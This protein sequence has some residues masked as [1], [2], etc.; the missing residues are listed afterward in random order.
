[1]DEDET[2]DDAALIEAWRAGDAVAGGRFIERHF[3]SVYRFFAT[4]LAQDADD[5]TQQTFTDLQRSVDRLRD[6]A[7]ARAY[8][9]RI[10]RNHLYMTLRSRASAGNVFD[11]SATSIAAIDSRPSPSAAV[12]R[13]AETRVLL[14]ALR[15]IPLS[16]QI[17]LE[18]YYW[19]Q[20]SVREIADVIRVAPG[21]GHE[22]SVA[23]P[24]Q[25]RRGDRRG[26]R[27]C[28]PGREH[29][30]RAGDVG[31][32][33]PRHHRLTLTRRHTSPCQPC[34]WPARRVTPRSPGSAPSRSCRCRYTGR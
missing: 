31:P 28:G 1:M 18:L 3:L 24:R 16:A 10:A 19:E 7:S 30:G 21:Y 11:P 12:A 27:G 5:L 25:A 2:D 15:H 32:R 29:D 20:M 26:H 6:V 34:H 14:Q 13:Q 9:M 33:G 4:K 8:V 17:V 23:R 22:S